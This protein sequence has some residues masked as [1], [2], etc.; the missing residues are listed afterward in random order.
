MASMI[1]IGMGLATVASY[2]NSREAV[3][4]EAT[5]RLLQVRDATVRVISSWFEREEVDLLNWASQKLYQISLDGGFMAEAARRNAN[6]ELDH[7]LFNYPYYE[8]IGLANR[9]G[10][11]VASS[12]FYSDAWKE[13]QNQ[14]FFQETIK[15]HINYSGIIKSANTGRWVFVISVPVK[16]PELKVKGIFFAVVGL[17]NFSD[18]FVTPL[19]L[20]K[21][22]FAFVYKSN[23]VILCHPDSRQVLK[24][25]LTQY[26]FGGQ[27]LS[28]S[29]GL[30]S[31]QWQGD[32]RIVAYSML[33]P[34]DWRIGIAASR[35][36]FL[37]P[38]R[39]IG[40]IN[41]GILIGVNIIA[42]ILTFALYRRL[43]ADPMGKL[44][45]GIEQVG[46]Q[47]VNYS[48]ELDRQDEFGLLALE[49]NRMA[50]SLKKSTVSIQELQESQ[51]RF[52]DVVEN[53]GDW[54]WEMDHQ[55]RF[56]Y[57]S[58]VVEKIL[59]YRSEQIQGTLVSDHFEEQH[60]EELTRFLRTHLQSLNPFAGKVIPFR[61]RT[62]D[63]F[64]L[65]VN[66]VPVLDTHGIFTGFRVGCRDI[67]KRIQTEIALNN[68]KDA[69]EAANRAKSE[70]LANM[71]HEIRTP[72]NGIIG[73][74]G[75]LLESGLNPEQQEFAEIVKSSGDSLLGIINDIL[76]FSK[77]EA[78]KLEFE[79]I[80]F[81]L[82]RTLDDVVQ[83][84]AVRTREKKLDLIHCIAP[85]VPA[86]L[87]G[88]PGRLRQVIMNLAN[89][90]VKFTAQGEVVI[91]VMMIHDHVDS[92]ELRFEVRDTGIGIPED[93]QVLLF[94]SFSQV[95]ASTTRKF[96]GT[97][98]GLAISKKLVTM[99][100]GQIGV[101][102][103][104]NQGST[105]WFTARFEQQPNISGQAAAARTGID[106]KRILVIS[107]S[108]T[109][110]KVVGS[111][112]Q[113]WGCRYD[114]AAGSREGL[115]M[116]QQA[117]TE[118]NPY[119]IALIDGI[120]PEEEG[121]QLGW[122]IKSDPSLASVRMAVLTSG[123]MRGDAADMKDIGFEAYLQKP[124]SQSLLFDCLVKLAGEANNFADIGLPARMITRHSLL[125]SRKSQKKILLVED[126]AIN[127]MVALNLLNRLGYA[128]EVAQDGR[129]A[130][131]MLEEQTF[132]LVLMDVQMPNLD[133]YQATGLIRGSTNGAFNPNIPVVAMTANAMKGDRV[134][135]LEAGMNDYLSKPILP[136]ELAEKLKTWLDSS[137]V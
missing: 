46:K 102:S 72:M 103:K 78:G 121:K 81:D 84:L 105:F 5:L 34:T 137:S 69:A 119:A 126:N 94:Q 15:G 26:D 10:K 2:I 86:L 118:H 66:A 12:N 124:V 20:G 57:S 71:S 53:T 77:I 37:W 104:P 45:A 56:T 50:H 114:Y 129:I 49:F 27:L 31:G 74:A 88:D 73:M 22:G 113:S 30:S 58:P 111:Y 9:D 23:G 99:M 36:E 14:P 18:M 76:D 92:V 85:Q 16:G 21:R 128:A 68:A 95:D 97:G 35:D 40:I 133:G 109:H 93:R 91:D 39:R 1:T 48:I 130:L 125:D 47:G 83:I 115:R 7:H 89:N 41:V 122:A 19:R 87:K 132:D 96:G 127:Q 120:P 135:C 42:V 61:H 90:A 80:D 101:I 82:R 52:K 8:S 79:I 70:F 3:E 32:E 11:V 24:E 106:G 6:G 64:Q 131:Q 59:G 108:K 17:S 110:R 67:T 98:L 60:R 123:G 75:F 62:G 38:A 33:P 44:V 28:N 54:I 136:G 43:I 117:A 100:G 51:R 25:K 112:L 4:H 55:G 116:L 63:I 107:D 13:I 134:K 65:E 29:K